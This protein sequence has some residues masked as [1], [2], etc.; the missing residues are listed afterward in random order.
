MR[1]LG[2]PQLD[3]V[4]VNHLHLDPVLARAS[5]G[6]KLTQCVTSFVVVLCPGLLYP[7][8]AERASDPLRIPTWCLACSRSPIAGDW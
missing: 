3:C 1:V 2:C 5:G 7:G 6:P 8:A 4:S